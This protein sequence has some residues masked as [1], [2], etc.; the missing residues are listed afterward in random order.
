MAILYDVPAGKSAVIDGPAELRVHGSGRGAR[1]QV[2]NTGTGPN[3]APVISYIAPTTAVAA[4]GSLVIDVAGS[5]FANTAVVVFNA[6]AVPTNF[7]TDTMLR[8]TVSGTAGAKNVLVRD[9]AVDSN[10][11]VFTFT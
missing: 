9:L 2:Y 11:K 5:N 7:V 10:V 3:P 8:A 6:V 1:Y 4:A